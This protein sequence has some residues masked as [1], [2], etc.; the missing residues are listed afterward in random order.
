MSWRWFFCVL[1]ISLVWELLTFDP[2]GARGANLDLP[3][4]IVHGKDSAHI[5]RFGAYAD[6][7]YYRRWA[8]LCKGAGRYDAMREAYDLGKPDPCSAAYEWR[9]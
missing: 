5:D 6:H 2:R 9:R 8:R 7:Y 1:A 4:L 3:D